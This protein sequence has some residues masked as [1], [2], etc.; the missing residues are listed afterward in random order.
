VTWAGVVRLEPAAFSSRRCKSAS[1]GQDTT[2]E[3]FR[4]WVC[5]LPGTQ[6]TLTG[7]VGTWAEHDAVLVAALMA[8]AVIDVC[9][10]QVS[11]V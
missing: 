3:D 11:A 2:A 1:P 10:E 4:P 6:A 5:R 7:H 8:T 9:D